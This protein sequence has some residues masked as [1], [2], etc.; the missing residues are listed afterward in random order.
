MEINQVTANSATNC[1]ERIS[2]VK[3]LILSH[4]KSARKA[5]VSFVVR[6]KENK[7]KWS[8][9]IVNSAVSWKLNRI[10]IDNVGFT[11]FMLFR[12]SGRDNIVRRD[13]SE[14]FM[15]SLSFSDK[16]IVGSGKTGL[17]GDE[18]GNK[19]EMTKQENADENLIFLDIIRQTCVLLVAQ[20]ALH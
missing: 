6:S 14:L 7:A 15:A 17:A 2:H 10:K 5:F 1:E 19:A 12:E 4:E 11:L 20:C 18:K 9:W 3:S 13:K 16:Q 8:Q